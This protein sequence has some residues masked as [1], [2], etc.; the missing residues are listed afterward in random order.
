MMIDGECRRGDGLGGCRWSGFLWEV[1][2]EVVVVKSEGV[3]VETGIAGKIVV[4]G[5]SRVVTEADD[6]LDDFD[7]GRN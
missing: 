6:V 1:T 7:V 2:E 4:F 5:S 3:L